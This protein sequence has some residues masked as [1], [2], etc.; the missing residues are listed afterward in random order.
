MSEDYR[1]EASFLVFSLLNFLIFP[2]LS[3]YNYSSFTQ[4]DDSNK[5]YRQR[6][7]ERETIDND[8]KVS[9]NLELPKNS[10]AMNIMGVKKI[11]GSGLSENGGSSSPRGKNKRKDDIVDST[12]PKVR[13]LFVNLCINLFINPVI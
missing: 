5:S 7:I 11:L 4:I 2:I 1:F 10:G 13:Q 8:I 6:A 3:F 12:I 9:L